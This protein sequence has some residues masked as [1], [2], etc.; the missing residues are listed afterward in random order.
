MKL[1]PDDIVLVRVKAFGA[2]HKIADKWK[3]SPYRILIQLGSQP[4]FKIQEVGSEGDENIKVLHRNMLY[5]LLTYEGTV[6][7][8]QTLLVKA[9]MLMD[10]YFS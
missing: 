7:D 3:Q 6:T 8:K 1:A 4:V 9:N 2:D 5:P 10:L